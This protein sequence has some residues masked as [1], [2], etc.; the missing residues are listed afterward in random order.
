MPAR[1][2][3]TCDQQIIWTPFLK[4]NPQTYSSVGLQNYLVQTNFPT[5]LGV[6]PSVGS[7]QTWADDLACCTL[8]V[9]EK[10]TLFYTSLLYVQ[11]H[12]LKTNYNFNYLLFTQN[13]TEIIF[14]IQ[15]FRYL[16]KIFIIILIC[17]LLLLR[18]HL[19]K[20]KIINI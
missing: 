2:N 6:P 8:S 20:F 10:K 15:S 3:T 14:L 5:Y 17:S 1:C 9:F 11:Q 13:K 12:K 4:T 7:S 19:S 16:I 18:I